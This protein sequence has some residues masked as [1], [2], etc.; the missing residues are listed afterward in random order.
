LEKQKHGGDR[1]SIP[2]K[3]ELTKVETR[4][5]LAEQYKVSKATI[6]RDASYAADINTIAAVTDHHGAAGVSALPLVPPQSLYSARQVLPGT[7]KVRSGPPD[8]QHW[9]HAEHIRLYQK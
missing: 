9:R 1:K 7:A 5:R 6:E 8:A 3:E 4:Q 2:Q